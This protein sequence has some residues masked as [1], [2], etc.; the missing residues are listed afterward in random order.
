M[1]AR[2]ERNAEAQVEA[3]A[4]R[5][6]D[7]KY[8]NKYLEQRFANIDMKLDGL[9]QELDVLRQ[10]NVQTRSEV[11]QIV[12][13]GQEET[14]SLVNVVLG[15]VD[16]AVASMNHKFDDLS[17]RVNTMQNVGWGIILTFVG[18]LITLVTVSIRG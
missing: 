14:R 12:S 10:E 4:M 7:G 15:R 2:V 8:F 1:P 3:G 17:A 6:P 9:R 18:V 5:M 13:Q 16:D 11:R